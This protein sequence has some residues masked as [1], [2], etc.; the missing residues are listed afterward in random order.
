MCPKLFMLHNF[1]V[2]EKF[3]KGRFCVCGTRTLGSCLLWVVSSITPDNHHCLGGKICFSLPLR[4]TLD[5]LH[6]ILSDQEESLLAGARANWLGLYIVILVKAVLINKV[7]STVDFTKNGF[8]TGKD[9]LEREC[10]LLN[11]SYFSIITVQIP[12]ISGVHVHSLQSVNQRY[13]ENEM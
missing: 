12:M 11:V 7:L 2:V 10:Q 3:A 6:K 4:H 1:I 9:V 8:I 5:D 13:A